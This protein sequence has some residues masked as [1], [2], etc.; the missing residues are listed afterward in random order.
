MFLELSYTITQKLIIGSFLNSLIFTRLKEFCL[1][2]WLKFFPD[3]KKF[4]D[5]FKFVEISYFQ[6]FQCSRSSGHP[7]E[8]QLLYKVKR[9][10]IK[11]I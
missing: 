1:L 9:T 6:V 2:S 10:R 5:F 4:H 8:S 7:D 11:K 3:S